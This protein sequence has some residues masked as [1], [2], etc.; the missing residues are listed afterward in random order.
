MMK[1]LEYIKRP[2]V[3]AVLAGLVGILLGLIW[4]W[5]I[6]PVK[7]KD[8]PPSLLHVGYQE[9][10]LRMAID[11][12]G[13]N[14][15]TELALKRYQELGSNG[16]AVL[17]TIQRN[18]GKQNP[19]TII[20]F[21]SIIQPAG[22]VVIPTPGGTQA[23]PT[24]GNLLVIYGVITFGVIVLAVVGY[25]LFKFLR[26]M[27]GRG[28]GEA[29]PAQ[30]ARRLSRQAEVTDYTG[31]GEETPIAQFVTTYVLGD[32]L[33]D[34]S[35]GIDSASGEFL[36]ECGI[37]ISETIGV[38]DPKKVTAFE[39]WMFDKNDI[40]TVTKVLMSSH[41]FNDVATFQRLEAKGEPILVETGKQV[42]LE[43]A[44]LQLL[45]TISDV[46]YGR[47]ALPDNSF[48]ERVTLELA[49]W[50]KITAPVPKA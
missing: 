13:T 39:V 33:F 20:N 29:T 16:P 8:A 22:G 9:D 3:A 34:D 32:D 45:A 49:V 27:L 26:P 38:G 31:R 7:W 43:T 44:A 24:T 40:Q 17:L 5:V 11:S 28:G 4:G 1:I 15:D 18:P 21:T 30:Q 10:Y 23:T 37:G 19:A 6:Q 42:V 25:G 41:A 50:P 46:E 48:F 47:G 12:Y 14:G 2:V 36:G 35:F